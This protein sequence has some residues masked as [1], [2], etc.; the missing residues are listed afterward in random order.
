LDRGDPRR[1]DLEERAED[2]LA[3]HEVAWV[4]PFLPVFRDLVRDWN[5]LDGRDPRA[6][7]FVF[8]LRSWRFE[9]GFVE[10]D[11]QMPGDVLDRGL[12]LFDSGLPVVVGSVNQASC[13]IPRRPRWDEFLASPYLGQLAWL[14]SFDR[15]G[16]GGVIAQALLSS[17]HLERRAWVDLW[18]EHVGPGLFETIARQPRLAARPSLAL[19]LAR[20]YVDDAS[21]RLLVESPSAAGVTALEV[22]DSQ[23]SD[24]DVTD[25]GARAL[26]ASPHL[27]RLRSLD[28]SCTA[29]TAAGLGALLDSPHLTRVEAL[30]LTHNRS[31]FRAEAINSIES[32]AGLALL[33]SLD[34]R[35]CNLGD[36]E[37]AALARCGWLRTVRRLGLRDNDVTSAGVRALADSPHLGNLTD[38]D[39]SNEPPGHVRARRGNSPGGEGLERLVRSPG[40]PRLAVLRVRDCNLEGADLEGWAGSEFE[41]RL[42]EL[43]LLGNRLGLVGARA[44]ASAPW[45]ARLTRLSVGGNHLGNEGARAL[46]GSPHLTRLEVL[47]LPANGVDNAGATALAHASFLGSLRIL[48]LANN[49]LGP[50]AAWA[51]AGSPHLARLASLNLAGNS[52]GDTGARFLATSPFLRDLR[53]LDLRGNGIGPE[54]AAALAASPNLTRLLRLGLSGNRVGSSGVRALAGSPSLTRLVELDLTGNEMGPEGLEAL[55]RSHS[56]TRLRV[57]N[58]AGSG[59]T[60]DV[61]AELLQDAPAVAR[62]TR[63]VL[64]AGRPP[65]S[66]EAAVER[67]VRSPFLTR[68]NTLELDSERGS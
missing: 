59:V 42:T 5:A 67:V 22:G 12:A 32:A 34:L 62:L 54:G 28:L 20:N 13:L 41:A 17:P 37:A 64:S 26:A 57:L 58:L 19:N 44:F 65:A 40:L 50:R 45:L 33:S 2:L 7:G 56:L 4:G 46:A 52:I 16:G 23:A 39:L 31:G 47:Y 10:L 1:F 55:A 35:S 49:R 30:Q 38:L 6:S 68:L 36:A 8:R 9:R 48:S 24:R 53:S 61:A 43:D 11:L 51:L 63:L 18:E 29:V 15:D 27:T 60:P 21:L 25:E 14:R 3:A 66:Y